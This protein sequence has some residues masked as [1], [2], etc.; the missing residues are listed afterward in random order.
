MS[1][2]K[3]AED[4]AAGQRDEKLYGESTRAGELYRKGWQTARRKKDAD[5]IVRLEGFQH[6]GGPNPA[7]PPRSSPTTAEDSIPPGES[8]KK[9]K[10]SSGTT[11]QRAAP[12]YTGRNSPKIAARPSEPLLDRKEEGGDDFKRPAKKPQP[13]EEFGD[14]FA[15]NFG[16]SELPKR[17]NGQTDPSCLTP[18]P[19]RAPEPATKPAPAPVQPELA[20]A[21]PNLAPESCPAKRSIPDP[22]P[23]PLIPTVTP[24]PEPPPIA[25]EPPAPEQPAIPDDPTQMSL[26]DV[27]PDWKGKWTG[28]PEFEQRDESP[29]QTIPVHVRSRADRAKLAALL[30][31][32]I[33]D[34]TRSLWFPKAEI[35]RYVDKLYST[36]EKINPRH[37]VYI[38]SKGRWEKR[39][40]ADALE[41]MGVP[42][43]IVVEPQERDNYAAVM[44]PAKILVLPFSNLG[45]GSI[46]AR[47]WVWAHAQDNGAARH[48]IL[49]DNIDGFYRLH[50]NLK[51]PCG[52]GATF[53]AAEDF[54][55]RYENVALAGMQYFMFASRKTVIPPFSLNTRIYSCILI[56]HSLDLPERWRGRYNEDTDLSIRALKAGWCTVLFNAFLAYK[57]TTMTMKGG[58]TDE[59]Y[60]DDGRKQMA[61]SL[62]LQHPELVKIVWKWGR[63]QHHVHYRIFR[64]NK[65]KPKPGAVLDGATD[66]YGMQLEQLES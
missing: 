44:D 18:E 30:G 6:G 19:A 16:G 32:T 3:G 65:L 22:E 15:L 8:Q 1:E 27:P 26:I 38:I 31:Q 23:P 39:L 12:V 7:G 13:A 24:D 60:K 47:N 64:D 61:E 9:P 37:P 4:F 51:V 62:Q 36:S 2:T 57:I 49:D 20:P 53:R 33:T 46:P 50:D 45:Q 63:W 17:P 41:K 29:W 34:D 14:L 42:F 40:T 35:R 48:W 11:P 56:N 10:D 54:V 28:M 52:S 59:L 21:G 43:R 55:D 58:N 25:V 5:D 66:N